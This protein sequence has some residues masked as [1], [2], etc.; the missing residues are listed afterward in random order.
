MGT[1]QTGHFNPWKFLE[2]MPDLF[3][4]TPSRPALPSLIRT[5]SRSPL[6]NRSSSIDGLKETISTAV[7]ARAS[8]S[9]PP[10]DMKLKTA[11]LVDSIPDP[12]PFVN[13]ALKPKNPAKWNVPAEHQGSLGTFSNPVTRQLPTPSVN[14][15]NT[16]TIRRDNVELVDLKRIG[17]EIRAQKRKNTVLTVVE[18][19][20]DSPVRF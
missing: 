16:Y 10:V 14:T 2:N 15:G 19:L 1:D 3:T 12:A 9:A 4:R 17:K 13:R 6:L 11:L 8:M 18:F 5:S 20:P 7:P